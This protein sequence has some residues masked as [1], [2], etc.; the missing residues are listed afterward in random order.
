MITISLTKAE[1]EKLYK[2]SKKFDDQDVFVLETELGLGMGY[3][4]V[5]KYDDKIEDITDYNA[6]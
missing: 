3:K 5:V 1:I 4:T 2:F 6:F